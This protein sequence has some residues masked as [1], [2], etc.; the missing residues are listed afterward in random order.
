MPQEVI[1]NANSTIFTALMNEFHSCISF[2]FPPK[3]KRK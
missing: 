2:Q 1:I 3:M